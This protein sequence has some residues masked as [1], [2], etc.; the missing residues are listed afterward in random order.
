LSKPQRALVFDADGVLIRRWGFADVLEQQHGI[1]RRMTEKFF[2]GPFQE[3]LIG[4]RK[5]EN[6]LS[7]FLKHWRWQGSTSDFIELW[8]RSDDQPSL[9]VLQAAEALRLPGDTLCVASN[10]EFLRARYIANEMGF[11]TLFDSLYFSCDLGS[12]KPREHFYIAVQ[13]DLQL[14]ADQIYF[15]DDSPPHVHAAAAVGWNAYLF[16]NPESFGVRSPCT[17][18]RARSS[19]DRTGYPKSS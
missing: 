12:A 1:S 8:M 17:L 11:A 3:C 6:A 4:E 5:L 18:C 2:Q 14:S 13:R 9:D 15:W 10:Q 7:P 19:G 16:E